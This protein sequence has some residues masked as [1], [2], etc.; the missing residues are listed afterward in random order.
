M[1]D[2]W[3]DQTIRIIE[4]ERHGFGYVFGYFGYSV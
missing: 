4:N 3:K 2:F 1:V